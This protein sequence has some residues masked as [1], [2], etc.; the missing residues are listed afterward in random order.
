M[1]L[2]GKIA[3]PDDNERLD[4]QRDRARP[5]PDSAPRSDAILTGIGTVLADDCL[6]TDRTGEERSRPLLRIVLDSLL[7]LPLES[8]M[9]ASCRERRAGGHHVGG[10][11]RAP[12]ASG[13]QGR[14]RRS[15]RRRRRPRETLGAVV[16]LLAREKYLSLM[17]EAG[18][19]VNWTALESGVADK[20]FFYYAPKIL[21]GMQSL[22]G[23][24]RRGTPPPRR[25]DP[26]SRREAA[27]DHHPTNSRWKRG[28]RNPSRSKMFTGIIEELG[29]VASL[30]ARSAGARLVIECRTVLSDATE[31][32]SIAV[33]G[34]CL[35]ALDTH[36]D[37]F[38][39]D[40]APETLARSNLGDLVRGV[41][42]ESG[43]S[44]DAR[45]APLRPH[46]AGP[47]G[48][49]RRARVALDEFGD[50]NWWLKV[51]VPAEPRSL[52]GAQRLHR[53]RRHQPDHRGAGSC[54]SR[55]VSASPS[56]PTRSR[57][58]SLGHSQVGARLNIEVDVLA[59]H[60]EKLLTGT[61]ASQPSRP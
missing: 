54:D 26:V 2:D 34:V 10:L 59:K 47:R 56:F 9:V 24:R 37:S 27:P 51:R 39:A 14:A 49:D 18:S 29:T 42:R 48:R 50:G 1:T 25:R 20:I 23:G 17:I 43:T 52:P 3:A 61:A 21:G 32:A 4:H 46:R 55:L 5:C 30:E 53:H 36:A 16:S 38:A 6:L 28:W 58:P 31:G 60:V 7:R 35:T 22:A 15:A 41:A 57:T 45:H 19:R 13:S 40:L 11:R 44:R 33:N 12:Q 8:K